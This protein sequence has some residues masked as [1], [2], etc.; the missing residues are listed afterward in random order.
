MK[1]MRRMSGVT[2]IQP[3]SL[4]LSIFFLIGLCGCEP[5]I[6]RKVMATV[7]HGRTFSVVIENPKA[8]IGSVVL[9]GGVIE[10]FIPGPEGTRLIVRECPVDNDG[11][12]QTEATYGEFV[13]HTPDYLSPRTFRKG[14]AIA[15]AEMIDGVWGRRRKTRPAKDS[16]PSGSDNRNSSLDGMRGDHREKVNP[17]FDP[18]CNFGPF[19]SRRLDQ[20]RDMSLSVDTQFVKGPRIAGEE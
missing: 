16:P 1:K 6:S 9:W 3:V 7:D 20:Q 8:Y 2:L 10:Q 13:A 15:L 18:V 12:P 19:C 14:M 5:P 11:R 4:G 17:A